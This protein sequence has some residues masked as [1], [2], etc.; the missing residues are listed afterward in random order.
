[1]DAGVAPV[2]VDGSYC[3]VLYRHSL[4]IHPCRGLDGD[5][6]SGG[7]GHLCVGGLWGISHWAHILFKGAGLVDSKVACSRLAGVGAVKASYGA[8]AQEARVFLV[9]RAFLG[10]VL[11]S[12]PGAAADVAAGVVG[13]PFTFRRGVRQDMAAGALSE[14]GES[15]G[16]T[17]RQSLTEHV[18]GFPHDSCKFPP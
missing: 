14:R 6:V 7:G 4:G 17:N 15:G 3:N 18:H 2:C 11:G 5:R 16:E 12:V 8:V 9:V 10:V 13:R 1:M